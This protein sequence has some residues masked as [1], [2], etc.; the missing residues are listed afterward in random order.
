MQKSRKLVRWRLRLQE[1]EFDVE[2][3]HGIKN[4]SIDAMSRMQTTGGYY[5]KELIDIEIP[6]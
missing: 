4:I 6:K 3:L 2:H 1:F 5:K